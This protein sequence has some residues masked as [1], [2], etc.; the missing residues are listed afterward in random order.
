MNAL[1][2]TIDDAVKVASQFCD[3]DETILRQEFEQKCWITPQG[4]DPRKELVD[5]IRDINPAEIASHVE[6]DNLRNW[7][8]A[9]QTAFQLALIQMGEV[10]HGE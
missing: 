5:L 6:S 3:E 2:L 8:V 1:M 4:N 7:C 9:I 10:G